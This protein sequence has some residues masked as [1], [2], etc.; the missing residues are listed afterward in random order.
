MDL[1]NILKEVANQR[2]ALE[3]K[4]SKSI[5]KLIDADGK[6]LSCE[7][8]KTLF[9][10]LSARPAWVVDREIKIL[11]GLD[12]D[13]LNQPPNINLPNDKEFSALL[14]IST[15]YS[16]RDLQEQSKSEYN[17]NSAIWPQLTK[18]QKD[19]ARRL[20]KRFW[21]STTVF[22]QGRP[23]PYKDII[24]SR[25]AHME[26]ATNLKFG[27]TINAH[28]DNAEPEGAMIEILQNALELIFFASGSPPRSTL[29]DIHL[30]RVKNSD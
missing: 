12:V 5:S 1:I 10:K 28:V 16:V 22:R 11:M 21:N 8:Q 25:I 14:Y 17:H 19:V 4:L 6:H 9:E 2:P 20:S 13:I 24:I 3:E 30:H 7:N 29:K 18:N 27:Y 26:Q 23:S 15:K